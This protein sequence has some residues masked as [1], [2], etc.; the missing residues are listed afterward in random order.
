MSWT[1]EEVQTTPAHF[2]WQWKVYANALVD[3][4]DDE[5]ICQ[6]NLTFKSCDQTKKICSFDI[7]NFFTFYGYTMSK[8]M[9]KP[10]FTD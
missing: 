2:D 1:E 8:L 10:L 3:R 4:Y 5:E 9:V 6:S 7:E